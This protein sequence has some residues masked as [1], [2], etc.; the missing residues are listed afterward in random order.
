MVWQLLWDTVQ[1]YLTRPVKKERARRMLKPHPF[2][3]QYAEYA[4]QSM[5]E[6]GIPASITLAQAAL[7]SDWGKSAPGHNFFG[8]KAGRSWKGPTQ[9]LGTWEVVHGKKVRV[10]AKFRKYD[11][12]LDSFVDHAKIIVNGPLRHAMGH[13][14]SARDFVTA[15]Q[16]GK[17][18][19]ATDP[20][21]VS[22]IMRIVD[23]YGL[24]ELDEVND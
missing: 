11:S 20:A 15:L 12:P 5:L 10:K 18:K 17:K 4:I 22:K 3:E 2:F 24:E 21:Y 13:V 19:Y 6:T 8:I 7:E 1:S 23:E 9:V 14:Q 16:S